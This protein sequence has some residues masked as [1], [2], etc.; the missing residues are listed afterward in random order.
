MDAVLT[1]ANIKEAIARVKGHTAPG[2]DGIP[3][4][5]YQT[6]A[7]DNDKLAEHLKELYEHI[8]PRKRRD[9]RQQ[10]T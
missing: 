3:I 6:C 5:P 2:K 4:E 10:S 9:A 8:D 7:A 1:I